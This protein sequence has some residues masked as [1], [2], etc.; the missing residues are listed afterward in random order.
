MEYDECLDIFEINKKCVSL[1]NHKII[2]IFSYY[3][4]RILRKILFSVGIISVGML[5]FFILKILNL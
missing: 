4:K 3:V 5:T 1:V 2:D